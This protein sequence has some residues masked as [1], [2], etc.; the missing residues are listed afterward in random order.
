MQL[1][2]NRSDRSEKNFSEQCKEQSRSSGFGQGEIYLE[3]QIL[4]G[5]AKE[6]G[7]AFLLPD[8]LR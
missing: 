4:P 2:G 1:R 8:L 6:T 3:E 7:G 5:R